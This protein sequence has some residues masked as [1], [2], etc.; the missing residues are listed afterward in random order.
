MVTMYNYD[1]APSFA[2]ASSSFQRDTRCYGVDSVV[3]DD[4]D[5]VLAATLRFY[6]QG[7]YIDYD[8]AYSLE[9]GKYVGTTVK[10]F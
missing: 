8:V 10:D 3:G 6:N 1:D 5:E 2:K 9:G 4:Y 7:G